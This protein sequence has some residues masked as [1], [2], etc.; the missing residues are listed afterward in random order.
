[1]NHP[2]GKPVLSHEE[3]IA[4]LASAAGGWS[5][6]DLRNRSSQRHKA[7]LI[8]RKKLEHRNAGLAEFAILALVEQTLLQK[9][10]KPQ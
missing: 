10:T 1:M 9:G 4:W 5:W 2:D 6:T 7:L 8:A 3:A